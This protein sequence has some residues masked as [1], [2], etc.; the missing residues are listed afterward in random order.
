LLFSEDGACFFAKI[1]NDKL[2]MNNEQ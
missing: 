1:G 2:V